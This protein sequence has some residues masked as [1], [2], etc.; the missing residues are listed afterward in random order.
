MVQYKAA[1]VITAAARET[2]LDKLYQE[3]SLESLLAEK[4][5]RGLF[6]STTLYRNFY[7]LASNLP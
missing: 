7:I 5:F 4:W 3:L 2:S 6:V 1:L